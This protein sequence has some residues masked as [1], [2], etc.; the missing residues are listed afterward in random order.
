MYKRQAIDG[1]PIVAVGDQSSIVAD[2][3]AYLVKIFVLLTR[4]SANTNFVFCESGVVSANALY[5]ELFLKLMHKLW[6]IFF[7][8]RKESGTKSS[9]PSAHIYRHMVF[10]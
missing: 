9:I 1:R 8:T 2:K 6:T 4:N 10:T 3:K 7:D 5:D